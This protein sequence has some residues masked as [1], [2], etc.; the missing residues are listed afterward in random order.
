MSENAPVNAR[1]LL[2][3]GLA[4]ARVAEP[5]SRPTRRA[6]VIDAVFA[7]IVL[8]AA[9]I[10]WQVSY[11]GAAQ[12]LAKSVSGADYLVTA[13]RWNFWAM[14]ATALVAIVLTSVPLAARR[15]APLSAFTVLL[16]GALVIRQY[17]TDVTFVA[18]ICAG[19][20]AIAHSRF[21]NAALLAVPLG[22]VVLAA[23]YWTVSR[24]LPAGPYATRGR[25]EL[26]F[27]S[28][29]HEVVVPVRGPI[30]AP[31]PGV[32]P[33]NAWRGIAV[34]VLVSL[35]AIAVIR[36]AMRSR[37]ARA[38]LRAEHEAATR[39]AVERE[40]TRIA[41]ELHDVVTHNVSV[42]IVQAGAARQV[43]AQSPAEARAAM[44]AVEAS[45]RAA[46]TELRHL[47]GLLSPAGPGSGQP[48][49]ELRPQPG[50][51]QLRSLVDRVGCTGLPVELHV[52]DDVPAE[53]PPGLDLAAFRVVQEALTNVLKHAGKPPT[54]VSVD[55]QDGG[56]LVEV[57]DA[58]P[59]IPAAVP[60][61]PGGGRGLIGLRER[62]AVYGGQL[63]AGPR[64]DGGWQV[65]A[66]FPV[67]SPGVA[68]GDAAGL[69]PAAARSR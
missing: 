27:S 20:S 61:V 66:R 3:Q 55:C 6:I 25:L 5:R 1:S 9:V 49:V 11:G 58:G 16:L 19:Y 53:L 31:G 52:A 59:P 33:D 47:L 29:G 46:M 26:I 39:R 35:V 48:D 17:A 63:D 18:V 15:L 4:L 45:G 69:A 44:L 21:R 8:T 7:A 37:E 67:D 57:S 32:G 36:N 28:R 50:L 56:L 51:A 22:G 38:R 68:P 65:R 41:G 2:R 30:G 34:L 24:A 13:S 10:A 14:P 43:L 42:M 40:R 12:S 62:V 23:T 64:P 60:A 54:S